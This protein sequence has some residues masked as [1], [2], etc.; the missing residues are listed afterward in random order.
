ME[1]ARSPGHSAQQVKSCVLELHCMDSWHQTPSPHESRFHILSILLVGNPLV[2]H[3]LLV[4]RIFQSLSAQLMNM[5]HIPPLAT[6]SSQ[7]SFT[8]KL[9]RLFFLSSGTNAASVFV[10]NRFCSKADSSFSYVPHFIL[11]RN[12]LE[13]T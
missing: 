1:M 13:I 11:G 7:P 4:K 3:F 8:P 6:G 12:V 9:L 10:F 5:H 2:E